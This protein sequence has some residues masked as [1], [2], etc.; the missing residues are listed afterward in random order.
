M[1][2][3]TRGYDTPAPTFPRIAYDFLF[4]KSRGPQIPS[5]APLSYFPE[6][7]KL[8]A[9]DQ[10]CKDNSVTLSASQPSNSRDLHHMTPVTNHF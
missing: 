5:Y 8:C 2:R 9:P 1:E 10:M 7:V 6:V 4:V 3:Y